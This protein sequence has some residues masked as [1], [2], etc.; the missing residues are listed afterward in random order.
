MKNNKK[1]IK[2]FKKI[3]LPEINKG[4]ITKFYKVYLGNIDDE[5][6]FEIFAHSREIEGEVLLATIEDGK[7]S[8]DGLLYENEQYEKE[9]KVFQEF[10]DSL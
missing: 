6:N 2:T 7:F 10:L 5:K 3:V 1:I 8:L 9:V 4:N